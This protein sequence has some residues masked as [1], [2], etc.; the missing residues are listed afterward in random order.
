M[1]DQETSLARTGAA[2]IIFAV[3]GAK[4]YQNQFY[5]NRRNSFVNISVT[6]HSCQLN[7]THCQGR[8]LKTMLPAVTPSMFRHHIDR[9]LKAGCR[10]ILVSGGSDRKGRVP[11]SHFCPEFH[12]AREQGL[13]VLV[14]SG[15]VDKEI[16]LALKEAGVNQV[17]MDIIGDPETIR[18]VYHLKAVPQD[19]LD[20][21]L[22]CREVGLPIA[23][24]IVIGL[25]FGNVKGEFK[26]LEMIR[27]VKPE[28]LVLV[29]LTPAPGTAMEKVAPPPLEQ[30]REVLSC[31]GR[32]FSDIPITLGCARPAGK[33]KLAVEKAAVD[34]GFA[35]IAY[36]AEETVEY[37][38]QLGLKIGF[39]EQCCSLIG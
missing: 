18:S 33:Y 5:I 8:L 28:C 1:P 27:T 12:Y 13:D 7:C 9:L 16:A 19:Y 36:P 20:A 29:I 10:G 25:H 17:L 24:H 15:L 32:L 39:R 14:H 34:E 21:M 38:L 4:H 23:P 2:D 35:G 30:V 37:A 6:G 26:A 11:L 31:A 22:N 3:P